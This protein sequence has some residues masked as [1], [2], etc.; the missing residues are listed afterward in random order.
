MDMGLPAADGQGS[1]HY[2]AD[3]KF[4]D[5][6]AINPD[7]RNR[8]AIAAS[9]NRLAQGM[10]PVCFQHHSLLG[11]SVRALVAPAPFFSPSSNLL[12]YSRLRNYRPPYNKPVKYTKVAVLQFY[13]VKNRYGT[14]CIFMFPRCTQHIR[15]Y[16][17]AGT[18]QSVYGQGHLTIFERKNTMHE[19]FF[20]LLE[21]DHNQVKDLLEKLQDTSDSAVKTREK[22]FLQLKK[23]IL[24]HLK[25]EEK[26][27]YP[28]LKEEKDSRR[29]AME[30]IEEHH[31]TE[32]VLHELDQLGKNEEHW[33]AKFEVF[34][35]LVEHHIEEEEEEIFSFAEEVLDEESIDQ[36]MKSFQEEKEKIKSEIS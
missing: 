26:T 29:K 33:A 25:A 28:A 30:S 35:E 32:L 1:I 11:S 34:K 6:P 15:K 17:P 13:L 4:V 8:T 21:K 19:D 24:P 31:V 27:L 23:E 16:S 9:H 5:H 12:S 18:R 3:W 14:P 2:R 22:L 20:Q 10:R 36:I 7:Y